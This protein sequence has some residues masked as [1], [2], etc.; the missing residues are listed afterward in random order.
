MK[1]TKRPR[2]G[3]PALAGSANWKRR[4]FLG[5]RRARAAKQS[6]ASTRKLAG[7]E[8]L[9]RRIARD[10]YTVSV[11]GREAG[12][13]TSG[14]PAPFLKKNIGMAYVP[15]NRTP[16]GRKSKSGF[17]ASGAGAHCG[18][19]VLQASAIDHE[20][21]K[22]ERERPC[23]QPTIATQKSTNG[24]SVEGPWHPRHHRLRPAGT[25]RR[26]IRR[27]CPRSARR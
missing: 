25:W 27:H 5:Q 23:I 20:N 1:S 9:E 24:S 11:A 4:H 6:G 21:R 2:P 18:A 12:R 7:F 22:I 17:A 8:M 13:V 3:K 10:G 15:P 14:G 26:G 16:S 19:A